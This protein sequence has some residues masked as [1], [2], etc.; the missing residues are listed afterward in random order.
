MGD[1]DAEYGKEAEVPKGAEETVVRLTLD[2]GAETRRETGTPVGQG[3]DPAVMTLWTAAA[4]LETLVMVG[5]LMWIMSG[6]GAVGI[7]TRVIFVSLAAV[8]GGGAL[9]F[10]AAKRNQQ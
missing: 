4:L 10:A 1:E 8:C 5:G 7:P 6:P 3:A 9:V 2:A